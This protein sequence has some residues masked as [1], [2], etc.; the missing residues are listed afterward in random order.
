MVSHLLSLPD[1]LLLM[2]RFKISLIIPRP[3]VRLG[4][5]FWKHVV[6]LIVFIILAYV[7]RDNWP[8][9]MH[10]RYVNVEAWMEN[11]KRGCEG[12]FAAFGEEFVQLHYAKLNKNNKTFTI[13]CESKIP[14]YYFLFGKEGTPLQ[15]W[16]TDLRT[17]PYA[18]VSKF[19]VEKNPIVVIL[20]HEAHNLFHTLCE[21][22]NVF[23]LSKLL[24]FDPFTVDILLLD[25]RPPSP[26]DPG[27]DTLFGK[28]LKYSD[29]PDNVIYETLIW[30]VIGYES[31]AN[32]HWQYVLPYADDFYRFFMRAFKIP[33]KGLDCSNLTATIIFRRDY[34]SHPERM[35]ATK[36]LIQRKFENEDEILQLVKFYLP[37]S[38]N[39]RAIILEE[40]HLLDQVTTLTNTD[41]LIGMHGAGMSY[42]MFLPPHAVV[43][44]LFPRYWGQLKHFRAFSRW[45]GLRYFVWKNINYRNERANYFSYIPPLIFKL[46]VPVLL[47]YICPS[48]T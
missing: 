15:S 2:A 9:R 11:P 3:L 24:E 37:P 8:R 6:F 33:I 43:F 23:L 28:I 12:N 26:I 7:I 42:T 44:E 36:G 27:W 48:V 1:C 10:R 14:K 45:R 22:Y 5:R 18:A 4:R 41:I 47:E 20:R 19:S 38:A 34:L 31:P 25:D 17:M 32:F 35:K 29:I 30:N 21:W 46:Y 39:V 13:P 16:L 40:M